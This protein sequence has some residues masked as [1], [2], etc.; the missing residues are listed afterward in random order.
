[1]TI[2][3]FNAQETYTASL[4]ER[5]HS[6]ANSAPRDTGLLLY[7]FLTKSKGAYPV[8]VVA[9]LERLGIPF[10]EDEQAHRITKLTAAIKRPK[11]G[12]VSSIFAD[13]H[14][15]DY[16]WRFASDSIAVLADRLFTAAKAKPIALLGTK[17]LFPY[18]YDKGAKTTLF[19]KSAALLGDLR[20]AGY[21]TGLVECNL[22][23]PLTEGENAYQ[24]A[25]AD[26]P[27]YLDYY[28]A[29]L[30][31]ASELLMPNGTLYLSVLPV[32]TRPDA[33]VDR[34][35]ILH[36]AATLGLELIAEEDAAL[37]YETPLFEQQALSAQGLYCNNW[38]SGD[39]WVFQK[40]RQPLTETTVAGRI[41]EPE[42]REYRIGSRRIKVNTQP[43]NE[44]KV[45][46]YRS[47]DPEG[48]VFTQVSRR[49]PFRNL[50]DVWSSDNQAYTVTR[51]SVLDYYLNEL[52][53]NDS[54][55]HVS[56]LIRK[57]HSVS[58]VE[59]VELIALLQE[60]VR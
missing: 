42:W 59:R 16:D 22:C 51:S 15:A 58:Q 35:Q 56:E 27:W 28:Q 2:Q 3:S 44:G 60:L 37:F 18:L 26:P 45:F 47:A 17:T 21:G 8:D 50:I 39:L 25:F 48:S 52:E 34:A 5:L 6:I 12:R 9:T 19:N 54:L 36:L 14:P 53:A 33:S 43:S 32:L 11:T 1:M 13:P 31:R 46:S 29:F 24:V 30:Q 40:A 4:A 55:E 20:Q 57:N 49:S 38:R 23:H 41:V 7:Y 10:L